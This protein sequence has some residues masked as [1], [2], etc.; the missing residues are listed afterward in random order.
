MV[1]IPTGLICWRR[2]EAEARRPKSPVA[3]PGVK[4]PDRTGQVRAKRR[5][6]VAPLT[7]DGRHRT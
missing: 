2:P 4:Y 5:S 6:L 1:L 7:G 3:E